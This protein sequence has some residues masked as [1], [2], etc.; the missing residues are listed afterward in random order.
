MKHSYLGKQRE[1]Y[2][3][4]KG[5]HNTGS[6]SIQKDLCCLYKLLLAL[7]FPKGLVS[8]QH[9]RTGWPLSGLGSILCRITTLSKTSK[10]EQ[11]LRF[12]FTLIKFT[13][14]SVVSSIKQNIN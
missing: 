2:Q 5:F 9:H 11:F 4:Y 13:R 7:D 8:L 1:A 14:D 3:V 6:A 12:L 10:G